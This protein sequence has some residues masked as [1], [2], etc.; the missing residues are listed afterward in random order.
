[1]NV[2]PVDVGL[3]IAHVATGTFF[4]I[5]GYRK[6][7]NPEVHT[8][9]TKMFKSKGVGFAE[10]VVPSGEFLGG[11]GLTFGVLTQAAALG[12]IPIMIGAFVLDTWDGVKAKKPTSKADCLAKCLCTAE[13][14]L[15]VILT[16]LVFTGAGF[17]SGD[18]LISTLLHN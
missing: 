18:N 10:W 6:L 7:F 1:M 13:G 11:L 3:L 17:F 16:T 12:L 8:R 5:T 15:L 14:Q 4:T 2:T 9:V